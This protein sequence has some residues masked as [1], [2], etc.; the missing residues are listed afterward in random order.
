M[1]SRKSRKRGKEPLLRGVNLH[2]YFGRVRALRG[3]DFEVYRPE[4]VGLVGDNGAGKSTLIKII[5]GIYRQTR[6]DV[7]YKGEKVRF[8]SPRE[9]MEVGI[10]SI[11]QDQ[12]LVEDMDIKRNFF[13][14]REPTNRMRLLDMKRIGRESMKA[15]ESMGLEVRSP[16]ASIRELSGGQRQGVAIARALHFDFDLVIL[17]EPTNNLSVAESEKV[18]RYVRGLKERN[19]SAILISHAIRQ[20]YPVADRII[21]LERGEKIGDYKKEETT[22]DKVE[23]LIRAGTRGKVAM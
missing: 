19:V 3:V 23:D 21:V 22:A 12:A 5:C 16:N 9:A 17:D 11:Q 18:Y 8:S 2:K 13:L 15:M 10:E 1:A 6:G 14:G 4:I 20:V 7:Y